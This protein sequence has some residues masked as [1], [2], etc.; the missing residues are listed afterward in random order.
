MILIS[1]TKTN[2]S[3]CVFP[4]Q[5]VPVNQIRKLCHKTCSNHISNVSSPPPNSS[6]TFRSSQQTGTKR[7][8]T[9]NVS[10]NDAPIDG[11]CPHATRGPGRFSSPHVLC[12]GNDVW[13]DCTLGKDRNTPYSRRYSR[14]KAHSFLN[15][16]P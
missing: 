16:V 4:R 10:G 9:D 14:E 1:I 2:D 11:H 8:E 5:S 12:T 7:N 13:R 15:V 6:K 3:L